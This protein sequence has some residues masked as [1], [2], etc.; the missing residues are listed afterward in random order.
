MKKL[1]GLFV[2]LC[3]VMGCVPTFAG[4][5][6]VEALIVDRSIYDKL[7]RDISNDFVAPV[8]SYNDYTYM[9]VKDIA[10]CF[11]L[12]AEWIPS[13]DSIRLLQ[14]DKE[15]FYVKSDMMAIN[16]AKATINEYFS[17][18]VTDNTAYFAHLNGPVSI[19]NGCRYFVWVAFD[20]ED[21][22]TEDIDEQIINQS[23]VCI[24][25][26]PSN[27]AIE[28]IELYNTIEHSNSLQIPVRFLK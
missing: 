17:E 9:S 8:L 14:P 2:V 24:Q 18:Y 19:G 6:I 21:T 15:A 20:F 5:N 7:G 1:V 4:G 28:L 11:D 16:I 27:G 25:I 23:H 26:E 3:M 13:T 22:H 12:R 10:N